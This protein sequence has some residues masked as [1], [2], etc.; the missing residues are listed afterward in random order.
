MSSYRPKIWLI[1]PDNFTPHYDINLGRA[2]IAEGWEVIWVTSPHQ[3]DRLPEVSAL[4]TEELFFRVLKRFPIR[5]IEWFSY[6]INLR[7]ALKAIV[8][9][10]NLARLHCRLCSQSP[11][12]LHVQWTLM[13]PLERLLWKVWRQKGWYIVFT[14][15]DPAPMNGSIPRWLY[16]AI[17]DLCSEADAVI[18]H[19]CRA[20]SILEAS[21]VTSHRIHIIEPG[22]PGFSFPIGREEAR[23]S[24]GIERS[25]PVLLMF[26][27]I[28][29]Y[30]GLQ[31]LLES[32]QMVRS[33]I[34]DVLLIIAG[35]LLEPASKY[36]RFI[37]NLGLEKNVRWSDGYVPEQFT[38]CYFS[39]ADVV[40]LPY[41]EASSSAVLLNAFLEGRPVVA[42]AVGE[43]PDMLKD[44]VSG[45]LVPP[46]DP[47]ALSAAI[48]SLLRNPA[49]ASSIGCK[50]RELLKSRFSWSKAA[51]LTGELYRYVSKGASSN[52]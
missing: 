19:G 31:T 20:R 33:S 28:K 38:A 16:H 47:V 41:L 39:A 5:N 45:L 49:F 29:P 2:L 30:K 32:L 8:Y 26:G 12:I 15:H 35:E 13:P 24:L 14:C 43:I 6:S 36:Q 22:P 10:F 9:P 3:F 44:G 7:R 51:K 52:P 18:V 11:A 1:D 27:Y 34:G 23:L 40:V 21:G 25:V 50:G 17:Y 48:V 46:G 4:T 37:A 42:S